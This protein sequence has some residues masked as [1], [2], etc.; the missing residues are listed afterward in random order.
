MNFITFWDSGS[1]LEW[2]QALDRYWTYVKPDNMEIEREMADL[3]RRSVQSLQP[4]AFYDW[5]Y[6][7]YFL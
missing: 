2:R 7:K 1:E 6:N 3:N 4:K 5:L